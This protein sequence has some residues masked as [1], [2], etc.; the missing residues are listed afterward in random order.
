MSN[1]KV[2]R[3]G[4]KI[5]V[6]INGEKQIISRSI[7]PETFDLVCDYISNNETDK[8]ISIFDN[9]EDKIDNFLKGYF[10][11]EN[12]AIYHNGEKHNFSSL[13]IRK[14]TELLSITNDAKPIYEMANKTMLSS[15]SISE[16]GNI[17]F[18]NA[19]KILLTENGNLILPTPTKMEISDSVIGKPYALS[20]EGIRIGGGTNYSILVSSEKSQKEVNSFVLINPFD[21][22]SFNDFE[23]FVKRYKVLDNIDINHKGLV[24]I[25]NE[26]L[27]DLPYTLFQKNIKK[28]S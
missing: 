28:V 21:I 10:Y 4:D 15:E 24:K 20:N 19:S 5:M 12:S 3:V 27:F 16:K 7:S 11:V 1:I 22:N 18:K 8:I 13:I 14:S 6:F 23:I 2:I 25:E 9:I 26:F 17:F